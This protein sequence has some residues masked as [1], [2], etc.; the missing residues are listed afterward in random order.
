MWTQW[1]WPT[2]YAVVCTAVGS[3]SLTEAMAGVAGRL[4]SG[5]V[6]MFGKGFG[7]G[8]TGGGTCP[9]CPPGPSCALLNDA[10]ATNFTDNL[11]GTV[12]DSHTGLMWLRDAGCLGTG[13]WNQTSPTVQERVTNLNAGTLAAACQDYTK[14]TYTDWRLPTVQEFVS[15]MQYSAS[16]WGMPTG[17]PFVNVGTWYWTADDAPGTFAWHVN[18][19]SGSVSHVEETGTNA[20]WAVR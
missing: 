20:G 14:G 9:A 16:G 13:T 19:A 18:L 5:E 1:F 10:M 15:L 2:H 6:V 7:S 11:N 3:G 17:H 12:T 4:P 8:A